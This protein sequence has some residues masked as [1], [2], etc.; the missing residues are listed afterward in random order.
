MLLFITQT[1][2]FL[3]AITASILLIYSAVHSYGN[4]RWAFS[5]FSC[6]AITLAIYAFLAIQHYYG[7]QFSCS[8]EAKD[9]FALSVTFFL[10][11]GGFFMVRLV[12][13]ACSK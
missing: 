1:V 7:L 8:C 12:R 2:L 4:L 6:A 13:G 10:M 11:C 3:F 9:F 5:C